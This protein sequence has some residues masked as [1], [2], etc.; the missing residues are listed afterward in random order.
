MSGSKIPLL[1]LR[2]SDS[3]MKLMQKSSSLICLLGCG[4]LALS[5]MPSTSFSRGSWPQFRGPDCSGTVDDA[6]P[7]V[8]ISPTNNV[9]WKTAVP[10]SPSSPCVWAQRI[11]L[12]TYAEGELQT[13]AY[14]AAD[15]RLL[16]SKGIKPEKLE[17]FHRTEG[18]PAA[19]CERA[20]VRPLQ[21]EPT[22]LAPSPPQV[23]VEPG[24]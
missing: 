1:R 15:G 9:I 14:N 10:W 12:T 7:P 24:G 5:A 19:G 16:W 13:R 22:E 2:S 21:S 8:K 4:A 11:F 3:E 6:S 23:G 17:L 18:S 20:P